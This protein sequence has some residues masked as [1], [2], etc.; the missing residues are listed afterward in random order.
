MAVRIRR[1]VVDSE[2]RPYCVSD[3][4]AAL[5][6]GENARSIIV[7]QFEVLS[8]YL[9]W[10]AERNSANYVRDHATVLK[11]IFRD[12]RGLGQSSGV[13]GRRP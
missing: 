8:R 9:S 7:D 5:T 3:I 6:A 1:V 12:L 4:D 13:R 2:C 11:S 10:K